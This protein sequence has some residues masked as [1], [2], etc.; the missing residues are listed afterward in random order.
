GGTPLLHG[1]WP[2]VLW[3]VLFIAPLQFVKLGHY[4]P[5]VC[6]LGVSS[7]GLGMVLLSLETGSILLAV[8]LG[9]HQTIPPYTPCLA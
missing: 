7:L 1:L 5:M 6:A 4:S 2:M 9:I 8:A 3:V